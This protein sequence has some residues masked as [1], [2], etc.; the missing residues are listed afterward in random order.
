ME[1]ELSF[2]ANVKGWQCVKKLAVDENTTSPEIVAKLSSIVT[3]AG[4]KAFELSGIDMGAIKA[5]SDLLTKGKRKSY[6]NLAE[7]FASLRPTDVKAKLLPLCKEEKAYPIA[8]AYLINC[9]FTNLQ[10]YPWIDLKVF[11]GIYPEVKISKPKG[12]VAGAKK[13]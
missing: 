8:E 10:L 9:I 12:R 1:E 7:I 2:F 3:S 6:N 5:Y 11:G 13:K 4:T